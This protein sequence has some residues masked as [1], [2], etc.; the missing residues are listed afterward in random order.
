MSVRGGGSNKER[1]DGQGQGGDSVRLILSIDIVRGR[2]REG[3]RE[4]VGGGERVIL[5]VRGRGDI[6][7]WR[8]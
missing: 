7:E 4:G 6:E 2:G 1:G 3:G 5:I 8:G